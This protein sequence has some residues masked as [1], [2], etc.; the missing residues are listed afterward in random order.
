M[1]KILKYLLRT[2]LV[3]F[4]LVNII[5]AFHAYKFTHF[6]EVG[7]V[8]IK[9]AGEKSG[10]DKTKEIFF[11][12]NAVKKKNTVIADSSFQTI[13]LKTKDSLKLEA[14]Y[15]PADSDFISCSNNY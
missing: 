13:S 6:Y 5:T 8:T 14:W 11:G 12:I 3:L 7:E 10:W 9:A 15:I 4:V 1:K 2:L